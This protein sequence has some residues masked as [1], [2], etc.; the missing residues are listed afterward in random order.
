MKAIA[1]VKNI[2]VVDAVKCIGCG[3]CEN[4]CPARPM[5]AMTVE[6][7]AVHRVDRPVTANEVAYER[8]HPGSCRIREQV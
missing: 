6:G 2:P 1:L 5:P 3:A 8:A 7:C 4:L